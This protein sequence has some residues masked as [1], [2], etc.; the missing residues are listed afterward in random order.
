MATVDKYSLLENNS[1]DIKAIV[2]MLL[3]SCVMI[4]TK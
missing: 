3:S 4:T 2:Y 1:E